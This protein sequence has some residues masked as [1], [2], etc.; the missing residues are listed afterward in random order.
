MHWKSGWQRAKDDF[1][2]C[3]FYVLVCMCANMYLLMI[4]F[5]KIYT[6]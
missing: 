5:F 4:I 3:L 1:V 2:L 6:H